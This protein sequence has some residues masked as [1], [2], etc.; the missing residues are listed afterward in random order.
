METL[1]E[2]CRELPPRDPK[3]G[4]I[5]G[6]TIT[7]KFF[8]DHLQAVRINFYLDYQ[9]YLSTNNDQVV[10]ALSPEVLNRMRALYKAKQLGID[11]VTPDEIQEKI[12]NYRVFQKDGEFDRSNFDEFRDNFLRAE[13][14]SAQDFDQIIK[15]NI[16]V[17]RIE[18]QITESIIVPQTEARA[19][20]VENYTK[21]NAHVSTFY[22]YKYQSEIEVS[23]EEV[24]QYFNENLESKYR[25]PEQRQ[26]QV[27]AFD[28]KKHLEIETIE[29]EK[30]KAYYDENKSADYSK[31]TNSFAADFDRNKF[32]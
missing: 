19:F 18:K 30:L 12:L 2:H 4:E 26:I 16:V 14:L 5:Y 8:L 15:D 24:E 29:D 6:K 13:R 27:V 32:Q 23:E 21:C 7:R 11:R 28:S 22:S 9:R 17:D 1:E 25:V 31:K 3:I 10:K 20:Y